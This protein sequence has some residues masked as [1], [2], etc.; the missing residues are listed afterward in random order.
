MAEALLTTTA[1]RQGPS[2]PNRVLFSYLTPAAEANTRSRSTSCPAEATCCPA[3]ALAAQP[4]AQPPLANHPPAK[5]RA[6]PPAATPYR[7][8]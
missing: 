5:P 3:E 7:S 1:E 4:R 8:C 6:Q 2:K